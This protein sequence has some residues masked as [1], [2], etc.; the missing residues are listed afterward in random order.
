M[1]VICEFV[2]DEDCVDPPLL[3][4]SFVLLFFIDIHPLL[5]I[6]LMQWIRVDHNNIFSLHPLQVRARSSGS[7]SRGEGERA[8]IS[9]IPRTTSS[10]SAIL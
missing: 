8:A 5:R 3:F 9:S 7:T 6:H 4:L 10:T 1:P 2:R